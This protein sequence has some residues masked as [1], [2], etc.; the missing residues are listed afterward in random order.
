MD[1]EALKREL[2]E[3]EA[4]NAAAT[5][6]GAAVGARHERIK[7]IRAALSAS[8]AQDAEGSAELLRHQRIEAAKDAIMR[9][10]AFAD[11]MAP[12]S[13]CALDMAT[14]AVD[15]VS[16]IRTPA[17]GGAAY[18]PAEFRKLQDTIDTQADM[19]LDL[20]D[21]VNQ[22]RAQVEDAAATMRR[23]VDW[24]YLYALEGQG[25]WPDSK[26][27]ADP[28]I[29]LATARAATQEDAEQFKLGS[30]L[31]RFSPPP[32]STVGEGK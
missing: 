29:R 21:E 16:A 11:M 5:S 6:W 31:S 23:L 4:K 24:T 22:A 14:A 10:P 27:I 19:I 9:C 28:L 18:S 20:R 12:P 2:A 17:E 1:R 25:G 15:A 30:S 26:T 7:G 3:L 32:S 13:M 8:H